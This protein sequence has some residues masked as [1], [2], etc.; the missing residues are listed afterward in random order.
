MD[1]VKSPVFSNPV[2]LSVGLEHACALDDEGVKCWGDNAK[3]QLDVPDLFFPSVISAGD[4]F[5]CALDD[6]GVK[7]WGDNDR[8]QLDVPDLSYPT[9]VSSGV[10]GSGGTFSGTADAFFACAIADK[11]VECWGL[12]NWGKTEAPAEM[13]DPTDVSAGREHACA[14]ATLYLKDINL[15]LK[16]GIQCWGRNKTGESSAPE[17]LNPSQVSSGA[18]HS[19]ALSDEGSL[20]GLSSRRST[21]DHHRTKTCL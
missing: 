6:E 12:N 15:P 19:C 21:R 7:C 17:L 1:K 2:K 11:K 3:G 20:L 16:R 5:T 4:N 18:L 13:V 10:G 9:Q 14:V 8:G